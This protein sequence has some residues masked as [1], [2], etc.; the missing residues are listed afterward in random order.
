MTGLVRKATLLVACGA[1]LGATSAM[2]GVPSPGNS[3]VAGRINLSGIDFATTLPD[4]VSASTK[5]TVTVRDLANNPLN[6]SSVSIDFSGC[7]KANIC[8]TQLYQGVLT[9]AGPNIRAFTNA[10]GVATL[11]G[12]G[13]NTV[14]TPATADA[15]GC[16]KVY[17]DGILIGTI[18][19]GTFDLDGANGVK[20]PDLS[21]WAT[22]FFAV[23]PEPSRSDYNN[24]GVVDLADLSLWA[25]AF[26]GMGNSGCASAYWP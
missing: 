21:L 9:S 13:A 18:N 7:S 24:N 11:V 20:L 25:T 2:A 6:A 3:T 5:I 10:S 1:I 22:D 16:A 19:V 12:T 26:F 15:N 14:S 8:D 4:T 23:G 17:A